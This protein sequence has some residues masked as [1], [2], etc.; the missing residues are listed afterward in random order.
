MKIRDKCKKFQYPTQTLAHKNQYITG[1]LVAIQ[2][3]RMT[4]SEH[5]AFQIPILG[6]IRE[7]KRSKFE[8][9]ALQSGAVSETAMQLRRRHTV[10]T[11]HQSNQHTDRTQNQRT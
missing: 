9:G 11:G 1:K 10:R 8:N 3:Q 7:D 4:A 2:S 6:H 5:D